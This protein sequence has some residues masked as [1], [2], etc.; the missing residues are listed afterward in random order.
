MKKVP[1]TIERGGERSFKNS[2]SGKILVE[3]HG[4][5]SLVF[6]AVMCVLR[7]RFL[8]RRC[9]GVSIFCKAKGLEVPIRLFSF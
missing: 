6:L 8:I 9:I 7:S 3:F 5:S 2:G 1:S 4:S